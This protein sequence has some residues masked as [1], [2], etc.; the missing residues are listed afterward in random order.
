M[1][2]SLY[3]KIIQLFNQLQ[4]EIDD[5]A[6]LS[7]LSGYVAKNDLP[8]T[9]RYS[10]VSPSV[11]T[12]GSTASATLIDRAVNRITLGQNITQLNLTF[13]PAIGGVSRDLLLRLVVTGST[14]PEISFA[15]GPTFDVD[16]DEWANIEPG[17]NIILFTETDNP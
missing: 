4:S 16:D 14:A 6:D 2:G 11:S 15:G 8:A 12:S 17:V 13:P 7:V 10:I 3:D 5:K 9:L 1:A